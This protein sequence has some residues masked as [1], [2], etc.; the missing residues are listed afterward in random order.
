L[1]IGTGLLLAWR[2]GSNIARP[3]GALTL[4][5]RNLAKGS[6]EVAIPNAERRDE[7]GE[8][9]RAV[10]VFK[11]NALAVRRLRSEQEA[12]HQHADAEKRAAMAAMAETIEI[13]TKHALEEIGGTTQMM[14]ATADQMAASATRTGSAAQVAAGA[15]SQAL[16]N[17][18][19]VA[20]AAGHLAES[21]REIGSQMNQ[22]AEVVG[23]AVVA[24][25]DARGTIET[26]NAEVASIGLVAKVIGE[27]AARTNLLALNAT[28]EAARAGDAGKGFAVV[29]SEVKLLAVQTAR[30]T[31][32]IGRHIAQVVSA[33]RASVD[34]VARLERSIGEI[35]NIAGSIAAAV[36]EQGA[37][38]AEIARSVGETATA[39][40]EMTARTETVSME[41]ADTGRHAAEV[42]DHTAK[43]D[44]CAG[45]LRRQVIHVVREAGI[46]VER[47]QSH[48]Y[49]VNLPCRMKIPGRDGDAARLADLSERGARITTTVLLAVG[50]RGSLRL[51]SLDQELPFVVRARSEG[52]LNVAFDL[53]TTTARALGAIA[54][55]LGRREAA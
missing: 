19:T 25:T 17:A 47:R 13:Q 27:I 53:D 23:R 36:E 18:Q 46:E 39:A 16:A 24:G 21:I 31:E 5:M 51:D 10:V 22:S 8:M 9:A 35:S 28:I 44:V 12:D 50:Q 52:V 30:S 11:E 34:A 6:L 4:V 15:A 29:A 7:L 48:R 45:D 3:V 49:S 43:L 33:T 37:A 42:R 40:N 2:I 26:L 38:T 41:A 54:E 55:G 14:A 20:E 32:E 1:A